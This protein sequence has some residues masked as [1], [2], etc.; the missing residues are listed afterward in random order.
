MRSAKV[1]LLILSVSIGTFTFAQNK[2]KITLD[3]F[4]NSVSFSSIKLSPD[5][6]SV[7]I[8]TERADWDR[9]IFSKNLWLYRAVGDNG[10]LIPLTQSGHDTE[11]QWSPDGKWIAFLSDRK[12]DDAADAADDTDDDSAKKDEGVDQIYLID[13]RGGEAFAVTSGAEEVHAFSWSADSKTLYFATRN[14][15]T[16]KKKDEYRKQWKDVVQYRTAERGDTIFALEVSGA[17]ATHAAAPAKTQTKA[18]KESDVTT[19]AR[20]IATSPLRV[21]ELRIAPD[22]SKLAFIANPIN[23]REEKFDDYEIYVVDLSDV[24][25]APSPANADNAA[26][27]F[28]EPRRLTHNQAVEHDLKWANDSRHMFFTIDV[29]DVTAP[30]RDLQPHLY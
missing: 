18:D 13:P 11:P 17:L 26:N 23:K 30:Y 24:G 21:D 20:A 28:A 2:P 7:V 10:T 9:Q 19:G 29:G 4:F 27:A 5:G 15:W 6:N 1:L 16:K 25:R 12:S 8:G 14:P 22:G 3:E